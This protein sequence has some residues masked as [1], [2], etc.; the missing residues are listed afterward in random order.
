[1]NDRTPQAVDACH[2]LIVWIVPKLDQF[3]RPRRYT[4]GARIE[5]LL[6]DVLE[7]L[8][9]AAY[10]GPAD[11][12]RHLDE[13]NS[14]LNLLRHMWRAAMELRAV[15]PKAHRFAAEKMV[16]I[17]MQIGGWRRSARS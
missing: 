10:A 5:T 8:L 9:R 13:A 7:G 17:G 6:L 4:L 16:D 11:K 1:M 15:D 12:V 3:P 2:E 14:R